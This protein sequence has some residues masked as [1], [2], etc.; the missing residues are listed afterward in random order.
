MLSVLKLTYIRKYI[1]WQL[2]IFLQV[3]TFTVEVETHTPGSKTPATDFE[4]IPEIGAFPTVGAEN[5]A[6]DV[7]TYNNAYNR[8]LLGTKSVPD[9]TLTVNYLPDNKIHQK[10]LEL[11]ENQQRAQF[12][13]TLL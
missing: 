11:E 12:R 2:W 8:K 1:K 3:L 13:I 6:I 10:L 4:E 9:I 5:V 7:V